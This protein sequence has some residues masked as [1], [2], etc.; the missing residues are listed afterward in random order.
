MNLVHDI[1][2]WSVRYTS[3]VE[4][5]WGIVSP[6]DQQVQNIVGSVDI[7]PVHKHKTRNF[8]DKTAQY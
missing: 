2:S 3:H 5:F 6:N 8:I 4:N 7:L 1:N